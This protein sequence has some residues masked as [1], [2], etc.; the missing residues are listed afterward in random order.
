MGWAGGGE[1]RHLKSLWEPAASFGEA[2]LLAQEDTGN[3]AA[4][5]GSG[6]RLQAAIPR[7]PADACWKAPSSKRQDL[8]PVWQAAAAEEIGK[9][10][11]C[12]PP[13]LLPRTGSGHT[14]ERD[15]E[16]NR[17]RKGECAPAS[18]QL[19]DCGSL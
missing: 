13:P 12:Y 4:C 3:P 1:Q 19:N 5:V 18:D 8:T 11:S 15:R 14:R 6:C 7:A 9:D 2:K 10:V 17:S 16:Q